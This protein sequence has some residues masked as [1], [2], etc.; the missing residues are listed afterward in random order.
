MDLEH[1]LYI[2]RIFHHVHWH[3][4]F[5]RLVGKWY[6]FHMHGGVS[7]CVLFSVDRGISYWPF[8]FRGWQ[9]VGKMKICNLT[10]RLR[11]KYSAVVNVNV[12]FSTPILSLSLSLNVASTN[13]Y[14]ASLFFQLA[15]QI[16]CILHKWWMKKLFLWCV[17]VNME[18]INYSRRNQMRTYWKNNKQSPLHAYCIVVII[19]C[20]DG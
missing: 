17:Q 5:F 20:N 8:R 18:T 4:L 7:V 15:Y 1:L 10:M 12:C 16:S 9:A 13:L 14:L 6:S 2:L 19:T 3:L 11:M